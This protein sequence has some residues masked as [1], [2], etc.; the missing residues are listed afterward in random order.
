MEFFLPAAIFC[1]ISNNMKIKV[2]VNET[3]GYMLIN[4]LSNFVCRS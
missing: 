2:C 1:L 4:V 3:S